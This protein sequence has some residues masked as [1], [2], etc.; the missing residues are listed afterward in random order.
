M[1]KVALMPGI[2]AYVYTKS[3]NL[4]SYGR[5]NACGGGQGSLRQP[6]LSNYSA[7][8]REAAGIDWLGG[9]LQA[10]NGGP[11]SKGSEVLI[12]GS[13]GL[14]FCMGGSTLSCRAAG[15][16]EL[17]SA[18]EQVRGGCWFKSRQVM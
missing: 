14:R 2:A 3:G 6:P 9:A 11:G 10:A 1:E 12:R 7:L 5:C 8:C 18:T 4:S 17:Y 16:S 13:N 15:S